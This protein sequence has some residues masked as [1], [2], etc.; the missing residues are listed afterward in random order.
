MKP[1]PTAPL[2]DR[3]GWLLAASGLWWLL[4]DSGWWLV[5]GLVPGSVLLGA[6]VGR[7]LWPGDARIDAL[8]AAGA[9]LGMALSLPAALV[10]P[11]AAALALLACG[12]SWLAIGHD[13]HCRIQP[14]AEVPEVEPG[15]GAAAC[16]ALDEALVGYF[17]ATARI[18]GGRRAERVC[19]ELLDAHAIIR[20][21]GW[22]RRPEA[23]HAEPTPPVHVRVDRARTYGHDYEIVRFAS[24]FEVCG[25]MPGSG[26]W[27]SYHGNDQCAA[28]VM[29]HA[30][31]ARPWL[32]CIHGYRMGVPWLDFR[33]FDPGWLHHRLGF[34]LIMPVLPLHG[35]RRC[36][37][38][39]GDEY[40][41]GDFMDLFHAQMQALWDLR[42]TLAW[43]RMQEQSPRVGVLGF[44]L[45]G[46]NAALLAQYAR[47]LDFVVAGIPLCDPAASL[48]RRM[49]APL[50]RWCEDVGATEQCFRDVLHPV[51]PLARPPLVARGH[52]HVFA[53][54]LDRVVEPEQALMLAAHW[55]TTVAWYAGGHLTFRGRPAVARTVR[56]AAQAAGWPLPDRGGSE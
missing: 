35:P 52:R 6:G 23:L 2:A 9:M 8:A 50:R 27:S 40:F 36:G 3:C 21:R 20:A 30:G 42:R 44:S 43:L 18:P 53:G 13:V 12:L 7:M 39:S 29:R 14:S 1:A 22:D 5:A 19:R 16:V 37:W 49:P 47:S 26:R 25:E 38:R 56:H 45:G 54:A 28:W 51:S 48:M 34:N 24:E 17:V 31:G 55:D 15:A 32:M 33:L 11:A 41:D 46:Y 4:A 10:S